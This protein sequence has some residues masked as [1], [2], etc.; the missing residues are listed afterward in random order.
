MAHPSNITLSPVDALIVSWYSLIGIFGLIGNISVIIIMWCRS[1]RNS[2]HFVIIWLAFVDLLGCLILP[3]RY[4]YFYQAY[5]L[6]STIC[7]LAPMFLLFIALLNH[8]SLGLV[9]MER[10]NAVQSVNNNRHMAN[11]SFLAILVLCV[12]A[13][14]VISCVFRFSGGNVR[15]RDILLILSDSS[16]AVQLVVTLP[17]FTTVIII[18]VLYAHIRKIIRQRIGP[19]PRIHFQPPSSDYDG[20]TSTQSSDPDR[21]TSTQSSD[22]GAQSQ[23]QV[24]SSDHNRSTQSHAPLD[25]HQQR[26]EQMMGKG[27]NRWWTQIPK[28]NRQQIGDGDKDLKQS[29]EEEAMGEFTDLQMLGSP[30]SRAVGCKHE[31]HPSEK[32]YTISSSR[33][34][35]SNITLQ[36]ELASGTDQEP[37]F[38]ERKPDFIYVD[39]EPAT[40]DQKSASTEQKPVFADHKPVSTEQKSASA[41]QELIYTDKEPASTDQKLTYTDQKLT[42]ADQEPAFIDQESTSMQQE[43]VFKDH[44]PVSTY[45]KPEPSSSNW[46]HLPGAVE[47]RNVTLPVCNNTSTALDD[48]ESIEPIAVIPDLNDQHQD[49]LYTSNKVTLMLF[50]AT[51]VSIFTYGLAGLLLLIKSLHVL[52]FLVDFL[53]EFT[54]INHAINPIIYNIVNESFRKDSRD[55]VKK[56]KQ[57]LRIA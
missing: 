3:L 57:R 52:N 33:V 24:P 55:F 25:E 45:Q 19:R 53:F 14:T 54:M 38:T 34:T 41:D 6:S 44:K 7:I 39:Q 29:G 50:I 32:N 43:P 37:A 1:I 17:T 15:C 56:V 51:A 47:E 8:F 21:H 28:F 2:H 31:V 46:D 9:A 49:M 40:V 18:I 30:H 27:H 23:P 48:T 35:L 13:S 36:H 22:H 5:K 10:H 11:H 12:V 26:G 20:H 4:I 42:S 16:N